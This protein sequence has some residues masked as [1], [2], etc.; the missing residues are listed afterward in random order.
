MKTMSFFIGSGVLRTFAAAVLFTVGSEVRSPAPPATPVPTY[1]WPDNGDFGAG[2]VLDLVPDGSGGL[3]VDDWSIPTPDG[4]LTPSN[5]E[6]T[7]GGDFP[8]RSFFD[9]FVD[10]TIPP[11]IT[12]ESTNGIPSYWNEEVSPINGTGDIT[13]PNGDVSAGFWSVPD[14]TPTW[15]LLVL[16]AGVLCVGRR[17]RKLAA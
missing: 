12:I 3:E 7:S 9:V 1:Y 11:P 15:L 13:G 14:R 10:L 8:A 6:I 4:T 17:S 2:A 5:S 16:G